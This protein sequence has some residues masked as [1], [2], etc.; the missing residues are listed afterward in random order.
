MLKARYRICVVGPEHVLL[1]VR[2]GYVNCR[3]EFGQFVVQEITPQ[4]ERI[5]KAYLDAGYVERPTGY[6]A[7]GHHAS[8]SRRHAPRR[9]RRIAMPTGMHLVGRHGD[10]ALVLHHP[11]EDQVFSIPTVKERD[12]NGRLIS[13][14]Q[15]ATPFT[16]T[17]SYAFRCI[18]CNAEST[19][20][21]NE[22]GEDGE[23]PIYPDD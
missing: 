8:R 16:T 4:G 20:R 9:P 6:W 12:T 14:K 23:F 22:L 11:V 19:F 21:L 3:G 10:G 18:R 1:R 5:W 15:I 17:Q 2:C 7:L 13:S